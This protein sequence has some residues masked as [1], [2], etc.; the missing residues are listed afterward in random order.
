MS[1]R[2]YLDA[3]LEEIRARARYAGTLIVLALTIIAVL[4]VT[5]VANLE[6]TLG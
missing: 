6:G 4:V 3:E 5:W 2:N 1:N